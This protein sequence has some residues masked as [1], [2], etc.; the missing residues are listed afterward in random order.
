MRFFGFNW[1]RK[2]TQSGLLINQLKYFWFWLRFRQDI[3]ILGTST[4]SANTDSFILGFLS[5]LKMLFCLFGKGHTKNPRKRFLQGTRLKQNGEFEPPVLKP[6]RNKF[7]YCSS[8]RKNCSTVFWFRQNKAS[9]LKIL[10]N[11]YE[12]SKQ[13]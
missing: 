2:R 4:Y 11:S 7:L 13:I 5:I 10:A 8:L 1:L 3:W 12:S 9:N 6:T